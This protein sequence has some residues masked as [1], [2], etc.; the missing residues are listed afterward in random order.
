MPFS[1]NIL[2]QL[3]H[4]ILGDA[5]T[6]YFFL[7]LELYKDQ[8]IVFSLKAG[9]AGGQLVLTDWCTITGVRIELEI[10]TSPLAFSAMLIGSF[11]IKAPAFTAENDDY[12]MNGDGSM[13]LPNPA[14]YTQPIPSILPEILFKMFPIRDPLAGA[15]AEVRAKNLIN[16][17][18]T[19][20]VEIDRLID[21]ALRFE[22][23][24]GFRLSGGKFA[25]ELLFTMTGY[26]MNAFGSRYFHFG[27]VQLQASI[28]RQPRV[29]L[30]WH[31]VPCH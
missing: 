12:I 5:P 31:A 11:E 16:C 25:L 23:G 19:P 2:C 27:N 24:L 10:S 21:R 6:V 15:K 22:G 13:C 8:G 20:K 28:V 4:R 3:A 18:Q 9:I 1:G 30:A 7:E 17:I 14:S 29:I 26:Y